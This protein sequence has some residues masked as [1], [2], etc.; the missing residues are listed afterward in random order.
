[1]AKLVNR[2]KL[3]TF[4]ST[5]LQLKKSNRGFAVA[6]DSHAAKLLPANAP[7]FGLAEP[8][9][10]RRHKRYTRPLYAS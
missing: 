2:I 6:S 8:E 10:P 7:R 9:P 4:I 1:M 5:P 3:L